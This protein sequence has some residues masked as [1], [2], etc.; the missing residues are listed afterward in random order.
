MRKSSLWRKDERTLSNRFGPNARAARGKGLPLRRH[1]K[2]PKTEYRLLQFVSTARVKNWETIGKLNGQLT[3]RMYDLESLRNRAKSPSEYYE[4][5]ALPTELCWPM[6]SCQRRHVKIWPVRL[7]IFVCFKRLRMKRKP[8]LDDHQGA[9]PS[10]RTT[11]A[12][13]LT[14]GPA[15]QASRNRSSGTDHALLTKL[16]RDDERV[17][18]LGPRRKSTTATTASLLS[19]R[20][21]WWSRKASNSRLLLA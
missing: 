4:S 6:T 17:S 1:K 15:P 13:S 9:R 21:K 16:H 20:A 8:N 19:V 5:V 3:T 11:R 18:Y 7:N 2:Y 10:Q 14:G 12:G